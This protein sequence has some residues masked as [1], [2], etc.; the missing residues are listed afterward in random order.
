MI[1]IIKTSALCALLGIFAF[2]FFSL[3]RGLTEP[4]E[5]ECRQAVEH[6]C[7]EWEC[8]TAASSPSEECIALL[9]KIDGNK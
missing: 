7:P 5:F 1:E 2:G 8:G 4:G 6:S 3:V 9:R